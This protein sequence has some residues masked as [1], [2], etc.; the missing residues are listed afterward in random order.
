MSRRGEGD[1]RHLVFTCGMGEERD[2]WQQM[3]TG[4]YGKRSVL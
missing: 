3:N 1:V 4:N 2:E